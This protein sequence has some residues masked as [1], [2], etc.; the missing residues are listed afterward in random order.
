MIQFCQAKAVQHERRI[1]LIFDFTDDVELNELAAM[2]LGG[3]LAFVESAVACLAV[4]DLQ[5]PIL[6]GPLADDAEPLIRRVIVAADRQNVHVPVPDP[7]HLFHTRKTRR[8]RLATFR[9]TDASRRAK[10]AA[11]LFCTFGLI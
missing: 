5:R 8:S 9:G 10:L 3:H 7:R 4:F 1:D 6:R 2:G 11:V